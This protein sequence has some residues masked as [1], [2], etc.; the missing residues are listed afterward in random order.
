[1]NTEENLWPSCVHHLHYEQ[2]S[3]FLHCFT[4]MV[5]MDF[6]ESLE[7]ALNYC[8]K[9]QVEWL[10]LWTWLNG[11]VH[12]TRSSPRDGPWSVS[13]LVTWRNTQTA[14]SCLA[15]ETVQGEKERSHMPVWKSGRPVEERTM[16]RQSEQ[17]SQ[18]NITGKEA[19]TC[20]AINFKKA[21]KSSTAHLSSEE[22]ELLS[23]F[24]TQRWFWCI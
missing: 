24:P 14:V 15:E 13:D 11:S 19:F 21:L 3:H 12:A 20:S 7:D 17:I 4:C 1:M 16:G 22:R 6:S 8:V 9:S 18:W 10:S 2:C 5:M 23:L